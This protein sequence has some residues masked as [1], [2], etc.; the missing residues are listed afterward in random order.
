[1]GPGSSPKGGSDV[2]LNAPLFHFVGVP[3]EARDP[4][5]WTYG[6]AFQGTQIFGGTGAGK[7]TTSGRRFALALLGA[8]REQP[9]ERFGGL[10][11]TAKDEELSIWAAP[12]TGYIAQAGR[13]PNEVTAFGP[14]ASQYRELG[15]AQPEGMPAFNFLAYEHALYSQLNFPA[16]PNLVSTLLT[17]MSGGDDRPSSREPYWDEAARQLLTNAIDLLDL[18]GPG[19]IAP[20]SLQSV[21][22][23]ILTAPQHPG[24]L[25][26]SQWKGTLCAELLRIACD[27]TD[28]DPDKQADL[29]ATVR[30]WAQEFPG[31]ADR[32]RSIVVSAFTSRASG[33]LRAP[34]REMF[35]GASTVKPEDTHLGRIVLLDLPSKTYGE[36]GRLAQ[37]IFKTVW[38]KATQ[39]RSLATHPNP[40][41]LWA[42]EAQYFVTRHDIHF[43]QTARANRAATVYL[44]QSIPNY[45]AALG[46]SAK[47]QTDSLL[48]CLQTKVFHANS[49]VV[50]NEWAERLFGSVTDYQMSFGTTHAEPKQGAA[51]GAGR[52]DSQ[53]SNLAPT[54]RPRVAAHEFASLRPAQADGRAEAW[55]FV[56]GKRWRQDGVS[57]LAWL[58]EFRRDEDPPLFTRT[59]M[60]P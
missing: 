27:R 3:N 33:L 40:V 49:D 57:T 37:V 13:R 17:A 25:Q 7:T 45:Y 23:I 44:T 9:T 29:T 19:S 54:R 48:S 50:T 1:M 21:Y 15:L 52:T 24:E 39:W 58:E 12:Q 41:F 35:C 5:S 59:R 38:Q 11:L 8:A 30:Y 18:A 43:Q 22:E 34:F 42:D 55:V 46:D 56:L 31:L 14:R 20:M 47:S 2:S 6:D 53:G 60:P 36:T 26:S 51:S 4:V 28:L 16:T 32:T 10:V